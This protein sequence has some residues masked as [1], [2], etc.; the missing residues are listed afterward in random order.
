M[1]SS[2]VLAVLAFAAS[3]G[4]VAQELPLEPGQ[5]VR[6][7][8]PSLDLDKHEERFSELRGD[9]L[10]LTS[11]WCPIADVERLEVHAGRRSHA[12]TGALIGILAG[13]LIGTPLGIAEQS[14]YECD[15]DNAL[16]PCI[17]PLPTIPI[18]FAVLGG[19]GGAVIGGRI[20]TDRWSEVALDRLRVRVVPARRGC[21]L[22]ASIAF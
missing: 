19:V 14:H 2:V 1:R 13:V 5:R 17:P 12:A 3:T 21:G 7:T 16:G 8:V 11:T 15:P 9:T 22:G 6:I 20:K 18:M 4:A 10:V